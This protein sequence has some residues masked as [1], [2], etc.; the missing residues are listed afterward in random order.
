MEDKILEAYVPYVTT[1]REVARICGTDHHRVK[2]V[3][4]KNNISIVK[5]KVG[6]FTD[7]HRRNISIACKGRRPWCVGK[8]MP[9]DSIYKNMATHLRFDVTWQWLK[10]YDDLE[11]LKMLNR[12]VTNKDKERY[13]IL[14]EEYKRYIQKFYYDEQFNCIYEKW[15]E[16]GRE[17]YKKPTID[18]IIP[19]SKGG[20]NDLDNLQ[21]LPWFENR[22]KNDM[23]QEEWDLL[24]QN[25]GDYLV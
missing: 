17:K 1:L 19:R 7:E 22:S 10:E 14:S 25:I 8:K 13:D 12:A 3:L 9:K 2:R 18:H 16:S 24:K 23:S 21:F 11:K 6:P 15:I 5:G 20:T 4:V